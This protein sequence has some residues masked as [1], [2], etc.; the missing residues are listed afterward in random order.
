MGLFKKKLERLLS[1]LYRISFFEIKKTKEE[2]LTKS[3]FDS[4]SYYRNADFEGRNYLGKNTSFVNGKLGF[5]SY[6]NKD[7][8]FTDTCIGRYTSIGTGVS[9]VIGS[10]P[11]EKIAAMHPAFTDPRPVF[12]FS[13]AKE[14]IFEEKKGSIKIGNDVWIGNHVKIMDG[15]VIGDGAV[16]G[17]GAVVTKD[18]PPYSISTGVP[19]KVMRYRFDEETIK[20]LEKAKWWDKDEKWISTHGT[21]FADVN[22]LLNVLERQA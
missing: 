14:H 3:R 1:A 12:G 20:R 16:V 7:G 17:A 5:G 21:D 4:G 15:V 18:L 6:I 13:Y 2:I 8:D 9:T 11:L 10:H 19:A 22:D